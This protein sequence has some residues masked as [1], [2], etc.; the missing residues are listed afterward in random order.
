MA[1]AGI[2]VGTSNCCCYVAIGDGP[3]ELVSST[4]GHH[5]TPSCVG[6]TPTSILVGDPAKQQQPTNPVNTFVEFKRV[7]GRTYEQRALWRNAK[8]WAFAML[9]PNEGETPEPRYAA[10]HCGEMLRLTAMDLTTVVLVNLRTDI[11]HRLNKI[12][13]RALTVTVPA[14]FDHAQRKQTLEAVRRAGFE[15]D[16]HIINEPSAALLAYAH[17]KPFDVRTCA[18]VVDMGAGTLDV[19]FVRVVDKHR[20]E[21]LTSQG[22]SD[23][24]GCDFDERLLTVAATHYKKHTAGKNL[25]TNKELMV[26]AKEACEQAKRTLSVTHETSIYVSESVPALSITR[27]SFEQS[28]LPELARCADTIVTASARV[29]DKVACVVLCGGSSRVPAFKRVV[30]Q[31]FPA[32]PI[33]SDINA[34]E[35]VAMGACLHARYAISAT[36]SPLSMV[37]IPLLQDV[38]AQSIGIRTGENIMLVL[39]PKDSPLPANATQELIPLSEQQKFADICVYQGESETTDNN[40]YLGFVRLTGLE[41]GHPLVRLRIQVN[42]DGLIQVDARDDQGHRVVGTIRL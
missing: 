29:E 37:P 40:T 21:I 8:H 6:Y 20:F 7:I 24:G 26:K 3:P 14:H 23:L 35:C 39:V 1:A 41:P 30:Q 22:R 28:I 4:T 42:A 11:H 18:A 19:S 34:D 25:R 5:L 17:R 33:L 31:Q 15:C 10:M 32:T 27:A 13:L 9:R 36:V 12:P 16:V 38:V 2:D